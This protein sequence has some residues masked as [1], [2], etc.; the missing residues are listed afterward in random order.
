MSHSVFS[1]VISGREFHSYSENGAV[2]VIQQHVKDAFFRD[3]SSSAF[4]R[5]KNKI[6]SC[7]QATPSHVVEELRRKGH[8]SPQTHRCSSLS[9]EQV[10]NLIKG[11]VVSRLPTTEDNHGEDVHLEKASSQLHSHAP[12]DGVVIESTST[13]EQE[14]G[15][16][17]EEPERVIGNHDLQQASSQLH[18]QAPTDCEQEQEEGLPAE[19]PEQ[20]IGNHDEHIHLQQPSS[21]LHSQAPTDCVIKSTSTSEG[22]PAEEP[23]QVILT[24]RPKCKK[25]KLQVS[26]TD[27]ATLLQDIRR[28]KAYYTEKVSLTRIGPALSPS[29]LKTTERRLLSKYT[30]MPGMHACTICLRNYVTI[31]SCMYIA[32]LGYVKQY[33]HD[34]PVHL[35]A[36]LNLTAVKGFLNYMKASHAYIY[37]YMYMLL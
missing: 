10:N 23:E 17:A 35:R 14:E 8:L 19:E 18:S 25:A 2:Y 31:I 1:T 29:T 37:I 4:M 33:M 7:D 24:A 16:P 30:C 34:V 32:F 15:L 20:V 12:T 36:V 27:N 6:A 28:L 3:L 9:V 13:S 26:P 11:R 21:H 22:L 5:R